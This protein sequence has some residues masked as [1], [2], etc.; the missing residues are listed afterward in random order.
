MQV[1]DCHC[2]LYPPSF[3]D[4]SEVLTSAK[5][6][7]IT[8]LINVPEN[9]EDCHK[10]L[11]LSQEHDI[12]KPSLGLHP[13]TPLA[14]FDPNR[15]LKELEDVINLI[16]DHHKE[17]VC[18]GEVGLDFSPHVVDKIRTDVKESQRHIFT[19]MIK[20][21]IEFSLTLNVHSRSAGRPTIE[22]IREVH[23]E[24]GRGMELNVLM[25]AFDGS[26]SVYKPTLQGKFSF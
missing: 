21:A 10:V 6:A 8:A 1:V 13:V 14:Q 25:H 9:I 20:L 2:H 18:I 17:I 15:R 5:A 7:G 4:L 26:P 12:L 23:G 24:F 19:E 11:S 16:R 22:L 3:E